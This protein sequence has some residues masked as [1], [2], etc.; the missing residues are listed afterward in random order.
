MKV[1]DFLI[2]LVIYIM[3]NIYQLYLQ[4]YEKHG[5]PKSL[6][7][8]WCT[9]KK[10]E[11]L[12]EIIALGAILTQRTSWHNA[13]FALTNLK[14]KKLLS[15]K[16]IAEIDK[17]EKLKELIRPAGF[18]QTKPKRLLAFSSFIINEYGGLKKFM[19]EEL[20][21]A[22]EKLLSLYGIGPE[23]A[24]TILLYALDKPTFV[25]DEY[26]RRLVKQKKLSDDLTYTFLKNLFEKN[27]PRDIT[28][29]QN[30]H[31]LIIIEQKGRKGS[32]MEIV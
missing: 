5:D 28:I 18:Y 22:R 16:K 31:A 14:K 32:I 21:V 15:I 7:P 23:T 25:I 20:Q 6:W 17:P 4:L 13:N 26:T 9:K 24:D 1:N 19:D 8:Q 2:E 27:L 3:N 30:F 12:R 29:F 11:S 10:T